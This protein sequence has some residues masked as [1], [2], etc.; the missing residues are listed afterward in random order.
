MKSL[1]VLTASVLIA[2]CL[3]LS[4]CSW[5]TL[6]MKWT[7]S[8]MGFYCVSDIWKGSIGCAP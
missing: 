1:K 7:G 3:G 4:G 5:K 8:A 6:V 2:V